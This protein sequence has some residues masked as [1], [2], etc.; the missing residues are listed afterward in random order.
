MP[1][2]G[3]SRKTTVVLDIWHRFHG[4]APCDRVDVTHPTFPTRLWSTDAW[5][6]RLRSREKAWTTRQRK[7]DAP[8]SLVAPSTLFPLT[9]WHPLQSPFGA[10]SPMMRSLAAR[11]D[12]HFDGERDGVRGRRFSSRSCRPRRWSPKTS[13]SWHRRF[14]PLRRWE[15]WCCCSCRARARW[16]MPCRQSR[17]RERRP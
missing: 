15:C 16:D 8:G 2:F 10:G 11:D 1:P 5:V 6:P 17:A 12:L 14:A 3:F 13:S 4:R 7:H 9:V